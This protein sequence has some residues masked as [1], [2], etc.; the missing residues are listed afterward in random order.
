MTAC[1]SSAPLAF[2]ATDGVVVVVNG[3]GVLDDQVKV[4]ELKLKPI[5]AFAAVETRA[6]DWANVIT[7][8]EEDA[9]AYVWK[10]DQRVI[11]QVGQDRPP[12]N[13]TTTTAGSSQR[14]A[15]AWLGFGM[16]PCPLHRSRR[17]HRQD[18]RRGAVGR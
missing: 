15:R 16:R 14:H 7:C 12:A 6:R 3:D 1:G 4:E 9:Q 18:H 17:E 10:F 2:V 11:G 13:I 5:V 8:H